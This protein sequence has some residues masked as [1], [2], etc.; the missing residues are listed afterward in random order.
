MNKLVYILLLVSLSAMGQERTT[1]Q[2]HIV[3]GGAV[4]AGVFVINK[5]TAA[6]TKTDANGNFSLAARPGDALV[7]YGTA[8][9]VRE[10]A[11]NAASFTETPY[12]M[13]VKPKAY[14]LEEVVINEQV[15]AQSLGIVPKGQKQYTVAERRL[16]TASAMTYGFN[17][18]AIVSTDAIINAISG[19]TKMLKKALATERKEFALDKINGLYTEQELRDDLKIPGE[20]VQG[21]LFYAVEDPEC[22]KALKAKNDDL[23]KLLLMDLAT[24]YI[25]L[26]KEQ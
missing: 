23:A 24:K 1:L 7:V 18:G 20:Y 4:A 22:A 15:T 21:F 14:E 8:T 6:E 13:E 11:I 3:A 16:Y 26:T 10:F 5:A 9:E 12:V 25:A 17:M 2:G 19:R